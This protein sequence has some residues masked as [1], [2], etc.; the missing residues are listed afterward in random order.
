MTPRDQDDSARADVALNWLAD[1]LAADVQEELGT[2]RGSSEASPDRM[3]DILAAVTP[4]S[5]SDAA[6]AFVKG[7]SAYPAFWE[8][9]IR[10]CAREDLSEQDIAL[11]RLCLAAVSPDDEVTTVGEISAIV[12]KQGRSLS[13]DGLSEPKSSGSISLFQDVGSRPPMIVAIDGP[14][15][16]GKSTAARLLA[17]RLGFRFLDT[18]SMYRAVALAAIREEIDLTDHDALLAVANRIDIKL[19]EDRVL[20]DGE[21]VTALIRTLEVT[22]A[23]SYAADHPGVRARL[24][25]L[26]RK[27]ADGINVVTEG[28]DQSTTVFP[29]ADVKIFLTASELVRAERRYVELVSH[30]MSV[31]QEQVL[32]KHRELDQRSA[33]PQVRSLLNVDDTI[34]VLTDGLSPDEVVDELVA[35]VV[36]ERT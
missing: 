15:G 35:I 25:L 14:A 16:A 31:T 21:D 13:F 23:T 32:A 4:V 26:Q 12:K 11:M 7:G 28:R 24:A 8:A 18:G 9:V 20:L 22:T 2:P 34:E 5:L 1:E 36:S 3:R 10:F 19:T 17:K 27:A 30:G 33:S 6:I 29:E